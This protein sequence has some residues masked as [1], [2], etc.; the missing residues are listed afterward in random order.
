[1]LYFKIIITSI[2]F[3]NTSLFSFVNIQKYLTQLLGFNIP[4]FKHFFKMFFTVT[5]IFLISY[6]LINNPSVLISFPATL[7]SFLLK[8]YTFL[9]KTKLSAPTLI[10]V[11]LFIILQCHYKLYLP[12]SLLLMITITPFFVV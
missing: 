10:N 12:S 1:M 4:V 7:L 11:S 9:L 8:F 5:Q 6:C 3:S 2:S